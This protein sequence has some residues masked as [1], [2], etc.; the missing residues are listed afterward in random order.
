V[1]HEDP[2]VD[3][4]GRGD[5]MTEL[6]LFDGALLIPEYLCGGEDGFT[7][8]VTETTDIVIREG[9][10][11]ST[12][13]PEVF[14]PEALDCERPIVGDRLLQDV[15]VWQTTDKTDLV[16]NHAI[17]VT[18]DCGTSRSKTRG[19]SY[20]VIGMF[21]DFGLAQ[22]AT[23][24]EVTQAFV[25]LLIQKTD[26]L[27]AATIAAEPKLKNGDLVKLRVKAMAI[28]TKLESGAYL[29]ALRMVDI[30]LGFVEMAVFDISDPFNHEGNLIMR[31]GNIKFILEVKVISFTQ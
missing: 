26:A 2:R 20:F 1:A 10:V 12:A 3:E 19:L 8:L 11:L 22:D 14:S 29:E 4:F 28:K 27:I 31:A 15:I 5:G 23:A 13:F 18:Y 17:E 24:D 21:I 30:F 16:E 6:S 9:T 7:V 25:N